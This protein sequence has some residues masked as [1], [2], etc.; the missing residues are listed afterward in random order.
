MTEDS[1][2]YSKLVVEVTKL[3]S[4]IRG[5]FLNKVANLEIAI[6][7]FLAYHFCTS[8][9]NIK[10]FMTFVLPSDVIIFDKKRIIFKKII[11]KYYP[12]FKSKIPEFHALIGKIRD[13]RN[14]FAHYPLDVTPA[15]IEIYQKTGE[16]V[17]FDNMKE[18]KFYKPMD[19]TNLA[20]SI[21]NLFDSISKLLPIE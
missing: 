12:S 6:D 1:A 16:I 13:I 2:E 4:I 17:L 18:R 11:E 9:V 10:D 19:I 15:G 5:A 8:D 7:T 3:S 14:Q 20:N 21:Q